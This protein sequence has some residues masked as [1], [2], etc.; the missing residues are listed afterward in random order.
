MKKKKKKKKKKSLEAIKQE[1]SIE[2]IVNAQK[3]VH[4]DTAGRGN[5]FPRA[6]KL[7]NDLGIQITPELLQ[8]VSDAFVDFEDERITAVREAQKPRLEMVKERLRQFK[9]SLK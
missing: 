6:E 2:A 1:T 9:W 3:C 4:L 5:H 7:L 8:I